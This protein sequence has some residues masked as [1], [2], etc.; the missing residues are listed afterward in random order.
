MRAVEIEGEPLSLLSR[1]SSTVAQPIEIRQL[2]STPLPMPKSVTSLD[3][4]D[5]TPSCVWEGQT[6]VPFLK[7]PMQGSEDYLLH[8]LAGVLG[9][10]R[11]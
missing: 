5:S 11:E 6:L 3:L 10:G 7:W 4:S 2:T 8:L 1:V 9:A